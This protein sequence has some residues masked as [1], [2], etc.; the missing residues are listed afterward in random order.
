MERCSQTQVMG[1]EQHVEDKQ[2]ETIDKTTNS[3]VRIRSRP[4][5]VKKKHTTID[6][7]DN[8][9]YEETLSCCMITIVIKKKEGVYPNYRDS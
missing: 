2:Q 5:K 6:G 3:Y 7:A 8:H 4:S 9:H 1:E